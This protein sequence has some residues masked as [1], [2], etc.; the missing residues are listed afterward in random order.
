[1]H[2]YDLQA[3]VEYAFR[4]GGA[5][6]LAYG[7]IVGSGP[8]ASELHLHEGPGT[9]QSGGC[10][11]HRRAEFAGMQPTSPGPFR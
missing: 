3:I 5:E 9:A 10:G 6:R 7:S 2:E 4:R 8:K 11:G 1:M